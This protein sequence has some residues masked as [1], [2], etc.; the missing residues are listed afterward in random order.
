MAICSHERGLACG[1]QGWR[2]KAPNSPPI[3]MNLGQELWFD[4]LQRAEAVVKICNI[5][6]ER[7]WIPDRI[8]AHSGWGETIGIPLVWPDIPQIIWPELWMLPEHGGYGVDPQLPAPGLTQTTE[9]L[10]RNALTRVALDQ[11]SSWVM[12]TIHQ[13]SSLPPCFQNDRLH[14][15]H[16]GIDTSLACPNPDISFSI[17]EFTFNS[18]TPTITFVNRNLE[19]LR[20]FDVFMRSLPPLMNKWKSLRVIIVGDSEKGYGLPHPSGQPLRN[21]MLAELANQIDISRIHFLGRIPHPHLISVLQAST[22]HVYLSY[23]FVMGWSLR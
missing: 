8:L 4:S 17:R 23:P 13:A 19:R 1:I 6:K 2:Y 11:A 9:Q 14:V 3:P 16:E 7:N 10:G 15:I 18:S 22:V 12:P 5:L 20:G 21:V